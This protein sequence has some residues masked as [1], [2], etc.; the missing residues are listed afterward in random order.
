VIVVAIKRA[1]GQLA[2]PPSGDEILAPGDSVVFK[3]GPTANLWNVRTWP[4]I[5]VLDRRGI[6]RHKWNESPGAEPLEKA[7]ADVLARE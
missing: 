3:E 1:D 4:T 5:Y 2:F 7:V 6:I